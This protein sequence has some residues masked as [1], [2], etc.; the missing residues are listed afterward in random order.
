M[1]LIPDSKLESRE[2][3]F[4]DRDCPTVRT[5]EGC[6]GRRIEKTEWTR[7]L[8]ESIESHELTARCGVS[9]GV[10]PLVSESGE[11]ESDE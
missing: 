5:Q 3:T 11:A 1:N 2:P 8:V 7:P 10:D 4:G 6:P 9:A